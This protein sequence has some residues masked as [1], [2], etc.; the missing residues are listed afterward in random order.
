[1]VLLADN[2]AILDSA[3][4]GRLHCLQLAVS[5][6]ALSNFASQAHSLFDAGHGERC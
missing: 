5:L 3:W 1:V 6:M 2:N 4:H